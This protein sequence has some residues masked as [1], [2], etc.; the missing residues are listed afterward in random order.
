LLDD[1]KS[2]LTHHLPA[3]LKSDCFFSLRQLQVAGWLWRN[4]QAE[5]KTFDLLIK[6]QLQKKNP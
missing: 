3:G 2:S 5:Q 4:P 6:Q 1:G